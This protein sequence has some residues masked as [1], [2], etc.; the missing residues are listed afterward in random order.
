M[1]GAKIGMTMVGRR[2]GVIAVFGGE[3]GGTRQEYKSTTP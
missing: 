2:A 1:G 3:D